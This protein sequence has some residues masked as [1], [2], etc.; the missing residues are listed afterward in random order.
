MHLKNGLLYAILDNEV[1]KKY[2]L[3]ILRLAT[4]LSISGVD[5]FQ[6]RFKQL[7]DAAALAIAKKLSK[8]IHKRKK[9]FIVND[10]V[11]I[12]YLSGADGVHLGKGD[13]P[14]Y[15]ARVIL[16]K[17]KMIGRTVHSA[18]EF[19][20]FV[21]EP[22][23]YISLGPVFKTKTKPHLVP[24]RIESIKRLLPKTRKLAFVIGGI[25]VHNV[26][27]LLINHIKNIAVCRGILLARKPKESA[28]SLKQ[29]IKEVSCN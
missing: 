26:S 5:L 17:R 11:D 7:S 8:I 4:G 14:S 1:I 16:G 24:W 20:Q 25:N 13:I 23:D 21:K 22:I 18:G 2:D 29:C 12:A 15:S 9:I 6:F 28:K 27:S 3:D 10:R 19:A